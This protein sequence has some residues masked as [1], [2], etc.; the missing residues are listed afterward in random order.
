MIL[1]SPSW[2][3]NVTS[4]DVAMCFSLEEWNLLDKAQ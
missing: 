2:Q 3:G 4:E 1:L